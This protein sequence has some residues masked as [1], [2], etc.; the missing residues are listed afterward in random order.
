MSIEVQVPK[1]AVVGQ[2]SEFIVTVPAAAGT[3]PLNVSVRAQLTPKPLEVK[4]NGNQTMTVSFTPR[5]NGKHE[6]NFTWADAPVKGSPFEVEVTGEPVRD[7]S[8]VKVEGVPATVKVG[9][10]SKFTVSAADSAGPG[11][12]LVDAEGPAEPEIDL[13]NTSGGNFEIEVTLPSAGSYKIDLFWGENNAI[14]GSPFTIN[15]E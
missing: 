14:P 2:S 3:G 5:S 9:A 8:Q 6:F 1:T 10:K 15:A 11:P 13:R 4:D 12:L 7:A